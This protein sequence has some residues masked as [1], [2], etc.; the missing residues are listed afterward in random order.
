MRTGRGQSR[1]DLIR[2]RAHLGVEDVAA[3]E[4]AVDED[5]FGAMKALESASY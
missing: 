4:A 3:A 1:R 5:P 2:T